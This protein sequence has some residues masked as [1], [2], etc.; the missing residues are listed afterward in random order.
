ML[1]GGAAGNYWLN[2]S[3]QSYVPDYDNDR[4]N[5]TLVQDGDNITSTLDKDFD[6]EDWYKV[7]VEQGQY[8]YVHMHLIETGYDFDLRLYYENETYSLDSSTSTTQDEEINYTAEQSGWYYIKAYAYSGGGEYEPGIFTLEVMVSDGVYVVSQVW[9]ITVLPNQAP[10][11]TELIPSEM[12]VL[13]NLGETMTF[14]VN[15]TDA[16]NDP[17]TYTWLLDGVEVATGNEYNYTA[18]EGSHVLTVVVSD[19]TVSIEHAWN[20]TVN[21]PPVVLVETSITLEEDAS[22]DVAV[23]VSDPENDTV[24]VTL[25]DAPAFVNYLDGTLNIS[26]AVPGEYDFNLTAMDEHGATTIVNIHLTVIN[27]NDAPEIVS[28]TP[29]QNVSMDEGSAQNFSVVV[30]DEDNDTITY[31]W[32]LDGSVVGSEAYYVYTPTYDDAGVH[33]LTVSI[34]DGTVSLTFTWNITVNNVNRAPVITGN[35]T[36][37]KTKIKKGAKVTIT[38]NANDPDG[39]ALTYQ[40]YLDNEVID[41][42]NLTGNTIEVKITKAGTHNLKVVVS[43]GALSAESN[44]VEIKV[45]K[46][47]PTPGFE[48]IAIIAAMVFVGIVVLRRK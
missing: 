38:I 39:D 20:I 4:A 9:N 26:M 45:K 2:V 10:E 31:T 14:A 18:E 25:E 28:Y 24:T 15:A 12:E 5:A 6:P 8:I 48:V 1:Y 36:L 13:M 42:G 29:T 46:P 40:V 43:D 32:S 22:M 44:S 7:Y 3:V 41:E 35:I 27:I 34:S 11:F 19:G 30:F 47:E 23:N 16:D 17:L 21:L 33:N 37:D